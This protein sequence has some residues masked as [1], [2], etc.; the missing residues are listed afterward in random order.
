VKDYGFPG[1]SGFTGF[2][3]FSAYP[4]VTAVFRDC[5][6]LPVGTGKMAGISLFDIQV[7][8]GYQ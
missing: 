4:V 2:P 5:P 3:G 7:K 1:F 6:K 8:R